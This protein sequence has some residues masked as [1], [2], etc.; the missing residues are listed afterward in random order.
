MGG[1][2][3]G[4]SATLSPPDLDL[5]MEWELDNEEMLGL[6]RIRALDNAISGQYEIE[7]HFDSPINSFAFIPQCVFS[8]DIARF[9]F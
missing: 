7:V 6:L 9:Y 1:L 3:D 5:N 8:T 2:I 4:T